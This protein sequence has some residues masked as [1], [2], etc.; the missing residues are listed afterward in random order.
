[1]TKKAIL[2]SM[3]LALGLAHQARAIDTIYL[4]GSTAYRGV[5]FNL[6]SGGS[7]FWQGGVA[8]TISTYGNAAASKGS[9]MLF[10]GTLTNGVETYID[11]LWSGSEAGIAATTGSTSTTINDGRPL[12][13]VPATFLIPSTASNPPGNTST[14]PGTANLNGSSTQPDLAMADTSQKVS[15]TKSPTLGDF[16]VVGVVPFTWAKNKNTST[17]TGA[18]TQKTAT[19]DIVN[20]QSQEI[21]ALAALGGQVAS[22]FSGVPSDSTTLVYQ[23]GRN[24]GSGTRVNTLIDSG[25]GF[26]TTV[27]QYGINSAYVNNIWTFNGSTTTFTTFSSITDDGYESGGD[28]AKVLNV[29]LSGAT[30]GVNPIIMLGYLGIGDAGALAASQ[31]LNYNGVAESDGAVIQGQYTLWGHEHLLGRVGLSGNQ[32]N[33]GTSLAAV[34]KDSNFA[35][36]SGTSTGSTPTAKSGSIYASVMACSRGTIPDSDTGLVTHN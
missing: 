36:T 8:P 17:T 1:M 34:L 35:G 16:G 11:C 14:A 7:P 18:G 6:L 4:T 13:G 21:R 23:T 5:I 2:G 19:D 25:Y 28:V 22:Y 3:M 32:Q 31:W 29:E 24:K 27:D 10:H 20:I 9:Y 26:S 33:F 15:I 12:F 30:D